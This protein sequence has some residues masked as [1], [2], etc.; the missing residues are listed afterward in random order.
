MT[1]DVP[2]KW[3]LSQIELEYSGVMNNVKKKKYEKANWS[4]RQGDE[5]VNKRIKNIYIFKQIAQYFGLKTNLQ[6]LK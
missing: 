5:Q 1:A 6:G 2:A 4:L 3:I